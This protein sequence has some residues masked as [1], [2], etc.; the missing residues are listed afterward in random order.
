MGKTGSAA[1]IVVYSKLCP[2]F[3]LGASLHILAQNSLSLYHENWKQKTLQVFRQHGLDMDWLYFAPIFIAAI[4]SIFHPSEDRRLSHPE[5]LYGILTNL[6]QKKFIES[7]QESIDC[8]KEIDHS[9]AFC[10]IFD[11][12]RH[13]AAFVQGRLLLFLASYLRYVFEPEWENINEELAEY[14]EDFFTA[15]NHPV[16]QDGSIHAQ[17]G[18]EHSTI[19]L[20]PSLFLY[21][22]SIVIRTKKSS[23]II[24]NPFLFHVK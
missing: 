2:M 4:P 21:I 19:E 7:I 13:K 20:I 6:P 16:L 3:E 5:K 14:A 12:L 10:P 18:V 8:V 9:M 1:E 23:Q 17:V 11:D 22:E 15:E 24:Y